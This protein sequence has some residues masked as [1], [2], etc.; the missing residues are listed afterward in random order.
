[1]SSRPGEVSKWR[2]A[3]LEPYVG[4]L[5][6]AERMLERREEQL[7]G[8]CERFGFQDVREVR[9][10]LGELRTKLRKGPA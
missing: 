3:E 9:E 2:Q 1:M 8:R 6:A 4:A 5:A 7:A 10:E